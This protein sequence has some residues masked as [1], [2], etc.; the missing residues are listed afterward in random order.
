MSLVSGMK[1]LVKRTGNYIHDN[2]S[3]ILVTLGLG[4]FGAAIVETA[5]KA[6]EAKARL[7]ELDTSIAIDCR[8]NHAPV[9]TKAQKL[10]MQTKTV[11]PVMAPTAVLATFSTGCI[12][13]AHRTDSKK[14][15][16]LTTAYELS[17]TAR[18]EYIAK[19]RDKIGEKAEKDIQDDYWCEKTQKNMPKDAHDDTIINTGH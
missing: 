19:V 11:A 3:T 2:S 7:E 6:P 1:K 16:A 12:L 15:A 13:M 17:E 9:P 18:R 4:G 14:V 8:D 5:I 10:W